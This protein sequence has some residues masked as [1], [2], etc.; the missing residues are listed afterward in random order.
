MRRDENCIFYFY[1]TKQRYA[2]GFIE[3]MQK[4]FSFFCVAVNLLVLF[5]LRFSKLL[6]GFKGLRV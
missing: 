1:L 3:T 6:E 2:K 5:W 4:R